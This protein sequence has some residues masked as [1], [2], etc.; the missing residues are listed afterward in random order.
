[1]YRRFFKFKGIVG[2]MGVG[3]LKFVIVNVGD[4]EVVV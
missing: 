3:K 4:F 1:M 2:G